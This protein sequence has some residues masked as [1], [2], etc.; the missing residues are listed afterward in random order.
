MESKQSEKI[1]VLYIDDE[2]DNLNS[3]KATFRRNF[4][5]Y[6]AESAIEGKKILEENNIEIVLSD[7]RMPEMTG[8]EFFASLIE[9]HNDCMRILVTGYSDIK[10]VV[11]AINLGQ[12]YRYISKPWDNE[13]LKIVIE[14]A[15]E[16]YRLRKDNKKLM[17]TIIKVNSQLEFMLRQKLSSL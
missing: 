1:S 12:V 14:Q 2:V 4:E 17:D 5:I 11:D 9:E 6:T 16:V 13:D 3:F 15:S 8:V 10:A 7:Q